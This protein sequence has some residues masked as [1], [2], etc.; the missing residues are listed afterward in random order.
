M[1]KQQITLNSGV[2]IQIREAH[3]SDANALEKMHERLSRQT[4]MLRYSAPR[5]PSAK[6]LASVCK[7]PAFVIVPTAT[8]DKVIGIGYYVKVDNAASNMAELA[9]LVEDG[10]QGCGLGK[11]LFSHL[12]NH[13]NL[14]GIK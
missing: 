7:N 1:M 8:P 2:H 14:A 12:R 10:F 4:L 3:P 13:A 6:H 9:L 11:R 5:K